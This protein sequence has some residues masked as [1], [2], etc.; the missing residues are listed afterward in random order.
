MFNTTKKD[1]YD[2]NQPL[3][4]TQGV[5]IPASTK[6]N[7]GILGADTFNDTNALMTTKVNNVLKQGSPLLDTAR[8][9]AMQYGESRGLLNSRQNAQMGQQSMINTAMQMVAPDAQAEQQRLS[10]E[11][12]A[13]Y[14][15]NQSNQAGQ[16]AGAMEQ[17]RQGFESAMSRDSQQFQEHLAKLGYDANEVQQLSAI[18]GN[19]VDSQVS[20]M[21]QIMRTPDNKWDQ[22]KQDDFESVI[23]A[24]KGWLSSLYG[25][26]LS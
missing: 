15:Y 7:N 12:A 2:E 23:N 1:T 10:A 21:G 24:S 18:Y 4:P 19:L 26:P 20:A 17:Q 8:T 14:G 5:N 22:K 6:P 16:I 3:V 25:I 13:Q 11:Q 9:G